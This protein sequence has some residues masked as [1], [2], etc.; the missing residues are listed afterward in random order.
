MEKVKETAS[1]P[2]HDSENP[3]DLSADQRAWMD[4]EIKKTLAKKAS[5]ELDYCSLEDAREEFD[6][7]AP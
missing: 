6:L 3:E 7:D 1:G 2:S 4:G 5:G